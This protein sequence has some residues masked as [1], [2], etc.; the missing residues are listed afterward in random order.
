VRTLPLVLLLVAASFGPFGLSSPGAPQREER[1]R[2]N[3]PPG[4][5]PSGL[6]P[7]GMSADHAASAPSS[8]A[9][10]APGSSSARPGEQREVWLLDNRYSPPMVMVEAGESVRWVNKGLHHHTVTSE[11]GPWGSDPLGRG[12]EFTHTFKQPG[13]YRYYCRFHRKEMQGTVIV[14]E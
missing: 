14:K 4:V 10:R 12:E 1:G 2:P 13:K 11:A 6:A 3:C 5:A 8:P 9:S 7:Q